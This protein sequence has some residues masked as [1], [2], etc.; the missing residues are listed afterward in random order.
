[1]TSPSVGMLANFLRAIARLALPASTQIDYLRAI[2][3]APSADEMALE[4]NEGFVLVPQFVDAGWLSAS[5]TEALRELHKILA[6]M[7]GSEQAELWT[8]DA[9]RNASAWENVR[10]VAQGFLMH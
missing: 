3:A 5:D 1:M 8:E 7:S 2:G 10:T 4:F 6:E 9:L